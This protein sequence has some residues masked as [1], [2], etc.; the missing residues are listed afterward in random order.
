MWAVFQTSY[1]F[2]TWLLIKERDNS[3]DNMA[4]PQTWAV[5]RH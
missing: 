4:D 2:V 5:G 1:V 3:N